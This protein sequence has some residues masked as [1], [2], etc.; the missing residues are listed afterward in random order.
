VP[1]GRSSDRDLVEVA[2]RIHGLGKPSIRCALGPEER[3]GVRLWKDAGRVD[4][5][6]RRE[7]KARITVVLL[8]CDVL[9]FTECHTGR[10][11]DAKNKI[12]KR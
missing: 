12:K 1:I 3:F 5:V 4:E 8:C 11:P 10:Q 7:R 2:D 6:P 9:Q